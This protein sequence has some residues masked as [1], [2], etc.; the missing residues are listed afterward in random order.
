M[1]REAL[2]GVRV[3]PTP[4]G[5]ALELPATRELSSAS[6]LQVSDGPGDEPLESPYESAD[7]TQTE[8]S[9]SSKRS[10]R[11]AAAK[12]EHLCQVRGCLSG[13]GGQSGRSPRARCLALHGLALGCLGSVHRSLPPGACLTCD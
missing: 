13:P 3:W 8:V 5:P 2:A 11:G 7:E 1:C 12:K 6:A 4:G 9:V 10:E